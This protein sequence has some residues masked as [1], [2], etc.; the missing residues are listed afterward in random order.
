MDLFPSWD[1][2]V[3][4]HQQV[5]AAA[6]DRNRPTARAVEGRSSANAVLVLSALPWMHRFA[7]RLDLSP[8]P[9]KLKL[10]GLTPELSVRAGR[11]RG[12]ALQPARSNSLVE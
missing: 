6:R 1:T 2:L 10:L 3:T 4:A 11:R 9:Q 12:V 5:R 8:A 7:S